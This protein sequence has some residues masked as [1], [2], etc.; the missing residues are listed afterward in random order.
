MF[1]SKPSSKDIL[2]P[3]STLL[4]LADDADLLMEIISFSNRMRLEGYY[5]FDDLSKAVHLVYASDY[6][7]SHVNEGGHQ[8][9]VQSSQMDPWIVGNAVEGLHCTGLPELAHRLEDLK[10]QTEARRTPD[11]QTLDA[12]FPDKSQD[13]YKAMHAWARPKVTPLPKEKLEARMHKLL[14]RRGT[15]QQRFEHDLAI[16]WQDE[17]GDDRIAGLNLA[18]TIGDKQW[19]IKQ[20]SAGS[21]ISFMGS[22]TSLWRLTLANNTKLFAL[23]LPGFTVALDRRPSQS[24]APEEVA[25]LTASPFLV[26]DD[27]IHASTSH[28]K[29]TTP[30]LLAPHL[31]KRAFIPLEDVLN[32]IHMS[33]ADQ[34]REDNLRFYAVLLSDERRLTIGTGTNTAILLDDRYRKITWLTKPEIT[35][36]REASSPT[37]SS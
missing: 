3:E 14:K 19:F 23:N 11:F 37:P 15:R 17:L 34:P 36:I 6:Y 8:H 35:R 10:T 30:G 32:I 13:Y 1:F 16:R 4:E 33:D 18:C 29:A 26:R 5:H 22:E 9:F 2:V 21:N 20:R 12:D 31:L 7:I 24:I 27:V 25:D 28:A